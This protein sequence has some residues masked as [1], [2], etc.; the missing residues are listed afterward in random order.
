MY[1]EIFQIAIDGPG[2]A[3]KS[4]IAKMIANKLSIE[5]IDTGAMYRAAAY[6]SKV[7]GVNIDDDIALTSM[8]ESTDIDFVKGVIYLDGKDVSDKIR[9]AE[10][11]SLAAKISQKNIVRS[12]LVD[13]QRA[14]GNKKSIVMDGRDIGSNVL[15][16]AKFKIY[17]TASSEERAKRRFEELVLKGQNVTLEQVLRDIEERDFQDMNRKLNPLVKADDALEIDTTTM[18]LEEVVNVILEE[19]KNG[20]S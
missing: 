20:C 9:D 12:K 2:G 13:I 4:T 16:N 3:G 17:M 18:S 7:A 10:I 8:M 6:K 11:S 5:Y 15:P 1:N 14:M 19:V